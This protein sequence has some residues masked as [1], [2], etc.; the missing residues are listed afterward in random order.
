MHACGKIGPCLRHAVN[1][2]HGILQAACNTV[3][4]NTVME[5][6]VGAITVVHKTV[7]N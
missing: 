3:V 6:T 2:W 5:G 4:Q 7:V 1:M